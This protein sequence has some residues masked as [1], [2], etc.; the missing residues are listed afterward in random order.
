[1]KKI[2]FKFAVVILMLLVISFA[3]LGF[4]TVNVYKIS[5]KSNELMNG[6][7][8]EINEMHKIYEAYLEIYRLTFYH[9]NTK[10]ASAMDDY[11]AEITA[12]KETMNHLLAGYG[13]KITDEEERAVFDIVKDK[14]SAFCNSVDNIVALSRSGDKEMAMVN[15]TNTLGTI[16]AML[17]SNMMKLIDISNTSFDAGHKE[18]EDTAAQAVGA[19]GVIIILLIVVSVLVFFISMRMIVT[20]IRKMTNA[21]NSIMEDINKN[22]GDLTKRV[23]V[24][25]KDEIADL[26]KGVNVFMDMMQGMIG[27][28]ITSGNEIG[29]QQTA[30][31]RI[32]ERAN[33]GAEDTSSIMEELAAGMEE[34]SATV[35]NM[36][37]GTKNVGN[38]MEDM[39]V[40]AADGTDFANGMKERARKLQ[41][42]AKASRQ[43]ADGI[44]QSI[45]ADLHQSIEDSRQIEN[46]SNLTG[47]I[48]RIAGQTNL[49]ALNASIE[50][51]RA[52]EQGRGFAV[53]ADEIRE[54]ADD[55]KE[56]ANNIQQISEGVIGAV[57]RLADNANR[58]LE[59]LN[60]KVVPDYEVLQQT[61]ERYFEDSVMIDGIMREVDTAAGQLRFV[62]KDMVSANDGISVTVHESATGVSSVAGNTNELAGDMKDIIQALGRVAS[63]TEELKQ[64][65]GCFKKY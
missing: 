30:V 36:N 21:M 50:A 1:M 13:E 35:H 24:V 18:L 59:F 43:T 45:D 14:L 40:K 60:E 29:Q 54:L 19:V 64:K 28:I 17:H 9:I 57:T 3:A 10:L 4:L 63:V 51:A 23:P 12:N 33:E 47:D 58:L 61:G 38:S 20:P 26:A 31:S 37:E 2:G 11:E 25:T 44:I 22:E 6:E 56:A 55:S 27:G 15:V 48:L 32:V 53:V 7:V 5:D 62:M 49:L 46:I 41:E 39:A 34:V 16:N 65:T 52:G 42:E 8:V